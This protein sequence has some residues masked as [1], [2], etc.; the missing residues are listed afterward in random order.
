MKISELPR[1]QHTLALVG[2]DCGA[3]VIADASLP[4]NWTERAKMAEAELN[5]LNLDGLE[6]L[7]MGEESDQEP[8]K[9]LCP[10]ADALLAD[11]FDGDLSEIVFKTWMTAMEGR[12]AEAEVWAEH[13]RLQSDANE[14]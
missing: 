9:L 13:R 12:L 7:A 8:L 10:N 3:S 11:A 5:Q 1:L 14:G 2:V 4:E 6:T